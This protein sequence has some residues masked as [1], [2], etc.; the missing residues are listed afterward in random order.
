MSL[1]TQTPYRALIVQHCN[2][3]K[4]KVWFGALHNALNAKLLHFLNFVEWQARKVFWKA[5]A[6]LASKSPNAPRFPQAK[7]VWQDETP[8]AYRESD[9]LAVQGYFLSISLGLYSIFY[10]IL[11]HRLWRL[12]ELPETNPAMEQE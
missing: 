8:R 10:I 9:E 4:L 7:D 1:L 12:W 11:L 3:T 6:L 5:F 2:S